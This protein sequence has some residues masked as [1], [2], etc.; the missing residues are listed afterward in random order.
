MLAKEPGASLIFEAFWVK[1][2]NATRTTKHEPF[3]KTSITKTGRYPETIRVRAAR[4][5]RRHGLGQ[6]CTCELFDG[7]LFRSH[8]DAICVEVWRDSVVL[9]RDHNAKP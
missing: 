6:L 8:L 3:P 7:N 2:G 1:A 9:Q 5:Q 4:V